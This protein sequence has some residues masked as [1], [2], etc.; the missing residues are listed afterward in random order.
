MA[1]DLTVK[2]IESL[3]PGEIRREVPDGHTRGL[4]FVLQPSGAAS[5]A[6]R[7]R[8][9]GKSKK[10]TLGPYPAIDLPAARRLASEAIQA[11]ARGED[12]SLAKQAAKQSARVAAEPVRDLVEHV[13]ETFIERYSAKNSKPLYLAETRRLLRKEISTPWKGRRLSSITRAD[14]HALLDAVCDRGSPITANRTLAGFRK[15]CNWSIDRG[16]IETSPCDKVRAPTAERARD[17]V[18][19][20]DEIKVIWTALDSVGWPFGPFGK[21][22]MLTGQR[23]DEVA[24]MSWCE[25]DFEAR[26]WTIPKERAKNKQAH[27]VPLSETALQILAGLP[28]IGDGN[29]LI[30]T[31]NGKTRISGFSRAKTNIDAGI[32]EILGDAPPLDRWTYHDL[33]R[34]AASGMAGLG[35]APHVV[36]AVLNH[37]SGTIKGVAAVYNRYSYSTEKRAALEAWAGYLD[38][39]LSGKPAGNVVEF[40]PARA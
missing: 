16:L 24:S 2:A 14:V 7:Y 4:F 34:T 37:K 20:D 35:I 12:P 33:R 10:L 9:A 19:S 27:V 28:R 40:L 18:L 13:V 30:L 3:K 39:L 32:A 15:L 31:T 8:F 5:W 36:E 38:A 17:R 22:L 29:G 23:R 6:L 1:K 21:L 11:I 26:T 25:V